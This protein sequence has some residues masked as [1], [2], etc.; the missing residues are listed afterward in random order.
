MREH[1][2]SEAAAAACCIAFGEHPFL[3]HRWIAEG[4]GWWGDVI[5]A[6]EFVGRLRTGASCSSNWFVVLLQMLER[7]RMVWI[8]YNYEAI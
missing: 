2:V 1:T 7:A 5:S 3:P 8:P 4:G 6:E